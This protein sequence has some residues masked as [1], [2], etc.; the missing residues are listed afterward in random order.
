VRVAALD[1]GEQHCQF[2]RKAAGGRR[3]RQSVASD[4]LPLIRLAR[5]S[6]GAEPAFAL[7]DRLFDIPH[8]SKHAAWG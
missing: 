8:R 5:G 3:G 1:L 7:A 4:G 2:G 6:T